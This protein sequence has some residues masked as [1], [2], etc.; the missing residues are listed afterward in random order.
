[1]PYSRFEMPDAPRTADLLRAAGDYEAVALESMAEIVRRYRRTPSYPFIDTKLNLITG[2]D[3]A[4]GDPIRGREAV[5]GW[6]QGRGLEALAGHARFFAQ[7]E[8]GGELEGAMRAMAREVLE[9]LRRMR[10]RNNGR[11]CFFMFPDGRPFRLDAEG[12]PSAYEVDPAHPYGFSDLFCSKGMFAAAAYLGDAGARAEALEYIDCVETAIW[13]GSFRSDQIPLD[14]KSRPEPKEGFLPHGPFMIQIGTAALLAEAGMA[15]ATERG[16]RLIEH[17]LR[18]YVNLDGRVPDLLE[19]DFWEGVGEDG[20][21]FRE[22]DGCIVSDPGHSLEFVGLAL[23]FIG[24]AAKNAGPAQLRR[25][26]A[27]GRRMAPILARNFANGYIPGP[28]GVSKAFDLVS[29]RQLNTDM[30][31]WNLPETIRAAA[32]QA[33]RTDGEER[34]HC[35]AVWRDCHNAFRRFVRPDL[36]LMAYQTRDARGRPVDAIPATADADPGYHTGLSLIDAIEAAAPLA[37]EL[38]PQENA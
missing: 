28:Q 1:M 5:Y 16:L 2:E 29:R 35:L 19:G 14:P 23:K 24:A 36:H 15:D 26:R 32:Y 27:A 20:L 30:P 33:Q 12:A 7:R 34:E 37:A 13:D 31:W 10:A 38:E 6:I 17:E 3:F 11:L 8:L 25:L 22:A 4:A 9:R 18:T 21:P